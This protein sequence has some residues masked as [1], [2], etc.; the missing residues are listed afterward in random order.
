MTNS[1]EP[2]PSKH[3]GDGPG[4]PVL[5]ESNGHVLSC[6]HCGAMYRRVILEPGQVARCVRC[7]TVLDAYATFK[8]HAWLAIV[9]TGIIAFILANAFPVVFLSFQGSTQSATFL[10]AAMVTWNAGYPLV[11]VLTFG[12]GFAMPFLHLSLLLWVFG[13]LAIGRLP[14]G[15]EAAVRWID[16]VKPWSMVPVFLM[17][18]LVTIVKLVD[19]ASLQP[20]IGL[21]GTIAV[22]V[23]M[24]GLTRLDSERLRFMAHDAGL[25]VT[26]PPPPRPPSPLMLQRTW[27][28]VIGALI[29]Y[30][31][32]NL[33]PIMYIRAFNGNSGHTIMGGVVELW[34]M[35]SYS[36]ASVVFIASVVVPIGKLVALVVLL[37]LTQR[38]SE[39]AL[40]R[41]TR[42]YHLVEFIG[43]WSM[44]DVFVVILLSALARFGTLLE[45]E[46]STGAAAFGGVVVLTMLAAMGFDPRLAWRRA[47]YRRHLDASET[48]VSTVQPTRTV[49]SV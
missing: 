5:Q 19:L 39:V 17:G 38:S 12:V 36:V 29:L 18:A 15:F 49:R 13:A 24:T 47:G 31:P 44:L 27:A 16:W 7:D 3:P 14:L 28:L 26:H 37:I 40:K 30:I 22:A 4:T 25:S 42:L 48:V 46:P 10:D 35:G 32:A 11:S 1:V 6:H 21:F 9:L 20:G 41:R 23:I 2:D 34:Q 8:P 43:Q 33:L 45:F